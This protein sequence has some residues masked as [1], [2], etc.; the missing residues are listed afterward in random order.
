MTRPQI[1]AQRRRLLTLRHRAHAWQDAIDQLF[2]TDGRGG[3]VYEL[4]LADEGVRDH[5]AVRAD[6]EASSRTLLAEM[7][8]ARPTEGRDVASRW[9][10]WWARWCA[11]LDRPRSTSR[12]RR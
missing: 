3:F 2:D 9:E 11:I 10:E 7:V 4:C 12:M 6:F 1:T 8:A 5:A